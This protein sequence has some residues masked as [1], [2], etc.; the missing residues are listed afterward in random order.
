MRS[1]MEKNKE[2]VIDI[3]TVVSKVGDV[4]AQTNLLALNAAIE[5]AR[6]GEHGRGFAVVADEVRNLSEQVRILVQSIQE[7]M[8]QVSTVTTNATNTFDSFATVVEDVTNHIREI[9][10]EMNDLLEGVK[11]MGNTVSSTEQTASRTG[12][13]LQQVKHEFQ[14]LIS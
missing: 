14:A 11:K 3:V 9:G 6:A 13:A 2:A 8:D 10:K 1:V 12:T 4:A 7:K 5:A